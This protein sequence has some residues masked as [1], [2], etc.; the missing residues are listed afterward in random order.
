MSSETPQSQAV[1]AGRGVVYIAFAKLYFMI[2]GAAIEFVLPS[3]LGRHIFGAYGFVAQAVSNVNNV[4]VTGTIQ[5]VSR[6]ST[7]DLS[8]IEAVKAAGLRMQVLVGLPIALLFA[9]SSPLIARLSV[10]PGKTGPLA[11]AS[12]IVLAYSFYAVFV[13]S[14]N[15]ARAF[16]KQAGLD[17][18]FAT[19][20]A[21]AILA[22]AAAGLGVWGAIGGWGGAAL[23]ILVVAAIWVGVPRD[24]RAGEIGPMV[25][26][27]AGVA[28]Y[29]ILI[30]LI[31]SVDQLLLKPMTARWFAGHEG[32]ILEH[33]TWLAQH[34]GETMVK[35]IAAEADGQVGYYRA[36]QNLARLPY[37]LM[38]AV[39]FVVFPLV[40]RATFEK[41]A[42]RTR[43]Y[44]RTTLR[45]S[46]IFAGAMGVVLAVNATRILSVPY[47][48]EYAREGGPALAILAIANVAF[49]LFSIAGTILNGAGRT[50]PAIV[51]AG[52]TLAVLVGGLFVLVPGAAPGREV[53]LRSAAATGGAMLLGTVASLWLL[54]RHFGAALPAL[55]LARVALA[56]AAAGGVAYVL[57][58]RGKIITIAEAAV[59]GLVFLVALVATRELTRADL[60]A[61][62]KVARR[63]GGK[64][65]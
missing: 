12:L 1:S 6:Y 34:P 10:D 30:N 33:S 48:P 57:P 45:Y 39:T 26:Y 24:M 19:L 43:S 27:L 38:I 20:R 7:A 64:A 13:G 16:H 53:L 44:I 35:A 31:M 52:V 23:A 42:E 40:S 17:M 55:T 62:L 50:R 5:A 58:T 63:G 60:Q 65:A 28:L 54:W 32:W 61:V 37:Q 51:V 18:T 46:L 47:A 56:G 41:D 9:A 22:A 3:L 21:A 25:R 4:V 2:A 11:L 29:L 14:A 59:C 36:V 15:G 8:R 49:A